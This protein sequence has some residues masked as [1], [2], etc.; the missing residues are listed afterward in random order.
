MNWLFIHNIIAPLVVGLPLLVAL[1][2]WFIVRRD[3]AEAGR[4]LAFSWRELIRYC[5]VNRVADGIRYK[6]TSPL[7]SSLTAC[8]SSSCRLGAAHLSPSGE[9]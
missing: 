1:V 7:Y 9:S 2:V 8:T 6:M 5:Q 3:T 4:S